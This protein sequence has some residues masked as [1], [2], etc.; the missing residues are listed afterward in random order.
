MSK[1]PFGTLNEIFKYRN[2]LAHGKPEL[3]E[4]SKE[5][6]TAELYNPHQKINLQTW[7]EKFE[8]IE[9][10]KNCYNDIKQAI[11]SIKQIS[12]KDTLPIG[13]LSIEYHGPDA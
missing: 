5:M 11:E 12:E 3:I 1:R 4:R 8:S 2:L 7:W 9:N 10:C 6:E 13:I